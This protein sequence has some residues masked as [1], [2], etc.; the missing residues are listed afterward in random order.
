MIDI[1]KA[2]S[3]NGRALTKHKSMTRIGLEK[4]SKQYIAPLAIIGAGVLILDSWAT[5][6]SSVK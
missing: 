4:S 1:A 2:L 5:F 6:K 3:R